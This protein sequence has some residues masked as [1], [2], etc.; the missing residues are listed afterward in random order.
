MAKSKGRILLDIWSAGLSKKDRRAAAVSSNFAEFVMDLNINGIEFE[1][2]E[3]LMAEAIKAHYPNAFS[4]KNT[5]MAQKQFFSGSE[6]QFVDEWKKVIADKG[7]AE[8]NAIYV[9]S[10]IKKPTM[11][12]G[13]SPEEFSKQQ[14]IASAFVE[15]DPS[16]A[17]VKFANMVEDLRKRLMEIGFDPE[18]TNE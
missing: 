5:W 12:G 14:K 13:M 9:R 8:F 16:E 17:E 7:W 1:E 2:A 11:I 3:Q 4:I 6:K 15:A 10:D 18:A